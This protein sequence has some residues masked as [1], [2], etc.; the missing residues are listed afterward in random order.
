MRALVSKL[1]IAGEM[2]IISKRLGK[3]S[4]GFH[5]FQYRI[6]RK[7]SKLISWLC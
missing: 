3:T 5:G 6:H 7:D 1:I 4:W 2:E